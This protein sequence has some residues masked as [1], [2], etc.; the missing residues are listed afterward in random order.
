MTAPFPMSKVNAD[1][2]H[3]NYRGIKSGPALAKILARCGVA[4]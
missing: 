4:A 1:I 2:S 3:Y